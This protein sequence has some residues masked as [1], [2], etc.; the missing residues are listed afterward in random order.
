VSGREGM[1]ET[2]GMRRFHRARRR[3][4]S[5]RRADLLAVFERSGLSA[6]AFARQ[7]RLHYTTFCG[8]RHR[9]AKAKAS[10]GFVQ[11]ELAG[12]PAPVELVIELNGRTRMRISSAGQIELAARLLQALNPKAA[13]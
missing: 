13:C 12:A 8:W 10:P 5:K 4:A 7:H 2:G 3:V 9:R 11:V 1:V 6:A